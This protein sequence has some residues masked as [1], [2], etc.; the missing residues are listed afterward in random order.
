MKRLLPGLALLG[1]LCTGPAW[2]ALQPGATAPDFTA[3]ASVGGKDFTFSLAETLK[4]GPVVLYFYPKSFTKGCTIE[5]HAFAEAAADFQ[6][7]GAS[8]I[9]VSGDRIETQR[10]FSTKE[11]RDKF[12]IAADPNL[13]IIKAYDAVRIK[14]TPSGETIADR[15]SYVIAPDGKVLYSYADSAPEKH[16][17]NTLAVVRQWHGQ[18][19]EGAAFAADAKSVEVRIENHHFTPST[20]TVPAGTVVVWVNHDEF[21]HGIVSDDEQIKSQEL[22]TGE[23]FKWTFTAPGKFGYQCPLH[24]TMTGTVEVAP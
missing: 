10:E 20:L 18:H 22:G 21:P 5:A 3:E 23:T 4:K 16:I 24:E 14:P 17:E 12:P 15:I 19:K 13:S 2:A 1:G 8:L 11:C 7:A 9:G 6:A